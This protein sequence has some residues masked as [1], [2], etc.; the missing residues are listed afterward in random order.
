MKTSV[1]FNKKNN[2]YLALALIKNVDMWSHKF[3][4]ACEVPGPSD[5]KHDLGR[6]QLMPARNYWPRG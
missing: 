6:I 3:M 5:S 2:R 4:Y 1:L